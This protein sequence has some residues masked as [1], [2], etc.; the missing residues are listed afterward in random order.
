MLALRLG[1]QGVS[2]GEMR[3]MLVTQVS[4]SIP[5][6]IGKRRICYI[7]DMPRLHLSYKKARKMQ[8]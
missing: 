7:L 6:L 5:S 3:S 2:S 1:Y 8:A 4:Y